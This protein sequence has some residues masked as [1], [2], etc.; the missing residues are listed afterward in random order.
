VKFIS[1]NGIDVKGAEA[2]GDSFSK[3]QNLTT[4]D[5]DL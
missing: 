1:R 3:L 2:L 5:I 4:L